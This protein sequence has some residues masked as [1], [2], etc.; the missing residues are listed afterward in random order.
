MNAHY[1]FTTQYKG[2]HTVGDGIIPA[3]FWDGPQPLFFDPGVSA[4]GPRYRRWIERHTHRRAPLAL[5]LTHS[6]FDHAGAAPYLQRTIAN[7]TA[8]ASQRAATVFT[9]P[10]AIATIQRLNQVYEEE[11]QAQIGAEQV[12][13]DQLPVARVLADGDTIDLG[14]GNTLEVMA[15]PG[16]TRD[17]LSF[18][19][20][21]QQLIVTGEAVGVVE[22]AF[23]HTQFM[24]GYR[25]Y[26][27][28]LERIRARMPRALAIAHNGIVAGAA[29]DRFLTQTH[30]VAV[31]RYCMV[32]R[33]LHEH[34][35]DIDAVAERIT[36]EEYDVR[37]DNIQKR[38]PFRLNLAATITCVAEEQ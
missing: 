17:H 21:R 30:D 6:H 1:Q 7:T 35:G 15:T 29:V 10:T 24:T 2:L 22:G 14:E 27:D 36:R 34:H 9:R 13:F 32:S 5:L 25:D 8:W 38:E 19:F 23:M 28:S 16:H 33:Y 12:Q 31:A 26:L 37:P 18:Y 3:F 20:P 11:L 4:Y